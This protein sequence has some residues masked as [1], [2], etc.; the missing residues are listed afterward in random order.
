[1][2][3]DEAFEALG[4]E[5]A[6]FAILGIAVLAVAALPRLLRDRALSFPI[7]LV[8][9]GIAAFALPL[10]L[11]DPDPVRHAV[12]AEHLAEV[13]VIVALTNAGLRIDRR[14]SWRSW[15][16]TWRL[17]A[18][19]MPLTIAAAA[20]LGWWLLGFA[21]A[22]AVLLGAVLSPTD[23]VLA[24]E[25]QVGGPGQ[26]SEDAETADIDEP[27]DEDEVRF[28]LTSEAG[29]NDGLAFPYTNAAI[30]MA[31]AGAAPGGWLGSWLLIGVV[32]RLGVGVV[33]GIVVGRVLARAILSMPAPTETGKALTGVSAVAVT[34][35][36][37]GTTEWLGGYG[38]LATFIAAYVLRHSDSDHDYHARLVV[39]VEQL[40]RLLIAGVLVLLGGAVARGVLA[41]LT[42][43]MVIVGVALVVVVRP[44][45]GAI[46][47]AGSRCTVPESM[48]LSFFGIR[49]I[50]SI[51][52]LAHAANVAPFPDV[53]ELW[54]LVV[55][56]VLVSIVLHGITASVVLRRLDEMRAGER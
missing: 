29:L 42:V 14:F 28:G 12:L 33:V 36:A 22:V 41:D 19:T 18:V 31:A 21:P 32:Y 56:V 40:E 26:G 34:L 3:V 11:P 54:A 44:L 43:E 6:A 16:T 2:S 39:F 53:D 50:G 10:G 7:L 47:L 20:L 51:Y 38:F 5:G 1:M 24:A 15:S 55:F 48:A 17:L 49:G 30:A 35:T 25:V 9:M 45:A 4:T 27:A 52:Y 23:P 13:T 37:Y 8:L 46:A